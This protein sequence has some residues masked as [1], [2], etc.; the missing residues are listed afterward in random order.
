[1]LYKMHI[2]LVFYIE[3][4]YVGTLHRRPKQGKHVLDFS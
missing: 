4:N 3:A 1:M 2:I